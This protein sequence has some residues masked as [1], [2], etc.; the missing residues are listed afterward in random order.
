MTDRGDRI[1]SMCGIAG[2]SLDADSGVDRTLAAQA[3]LAGIAERGADAVGYAHRGAGP[4]VD[5]A[6]AADR[7]DRAARRSSAPR[8][9]RPGAGPRPR[10]HQGPPD[11]RRQQPPDPSRIGGRHPQRDHRERR[12]DLRRARIWRAEP[13]MTVDSEVIFA[14][15]ELRRARTRRSS[16]FYGAMA[17]AWID[18]RD[19]RRAD[20]ARGVGRP[21][22]L[23]RG[24][25]ELFF[26][27]TTVGAR[28]RR[29]ARCGSGCARPRSPRDGC[30]RSRTAGRDARSACSADRA[31]ARTSLLP[32][33]ARRTRARL[34]RAARRR[35]PP[36]LA[37]VGRSTRAVGRDL[38][39]SSR[40]RSAH[41]ELERRP[42]ARRRRRTCGRPA[43]R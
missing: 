12:R 38:T 23:G 37:A 40:S 5:G 4:A 39:P 6:Q 18:E 30:C 33:C 17:T 32:P 2:Y 24:R 15:V 28:G 35:S 21:L 13:E 20:L 16:S 3:L 27:S 25:H 8:P 22:W 19:P 14:L 34:P 42:G 43:T 41:E 11:D 31:Y 7:R 29:A 1:R 36:R 26:A 9:T 10:L